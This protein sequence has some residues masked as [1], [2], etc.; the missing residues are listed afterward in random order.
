VN[1]CISPEKPLTAAA[2]EGEPVVGQAQA[3]NSVNADRRD[4]TAARPKPKPRLSLSA[5]TGESSNG[6]DN[7]SV[8]AINV[9]HRSHGQVRVVPLNYTQLYINNQSVKML[10]DSSSQVALLN[11]KILAGTELQ[12]VGTIQVQGVFGEPQTANIVSV[13]VRRCNEDTAISRVSIVSA[14]TQI[15]CAVVSDMAAGHDMIL[16]PE[17][18]DEVL[19][20]PLFEKLLTDRDDRKSIHDTFNCGSEDN[21]KQLHEVWGVVHA[22]VRIIPKQGISDASNV[23]R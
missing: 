22:D 5:Q 13:E 19:Q 2:L 18:A 9:A 15:V 20:S 11:E 16:P 14:P 1:A 21:W 23:I 6:T 3:R 17:L 8:L 10:I 12:P 7:H 4:V